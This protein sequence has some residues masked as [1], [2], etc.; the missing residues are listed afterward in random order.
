MK[1]LVD[2]YNLIG[3]VHH[4]QFSDK[5]KEEKLI[6]FLCT[7]HFKPSV[8]IFLVF[9]GKGPYSTFGH[10]YSEQ[11]FRIIYTPEGMSADDYLINQMTKYRDKKSVVF[12]SSDNKI[13]KAA[14]EHHFTVLK[15]TEFIRLSVM[16][17]PVETKPDNTPTDKEV[18]FWMHQF[19]P[20]P[21]SK[22][23]Q[24]S[25]PKPKPPAPKRKVPPGSVLD[26]D[27]WLKAFTD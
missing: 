22:P 18:N 23:K 11:H 25:V 17:E 2:A 4:I 26:I 10:A 9:D 27:Y 19:A 12:V 21:P 13:R 8:R 20:P 1:Y 24:K 16:P 7:R 5:D 3:A 6:Q 15:C 14:K